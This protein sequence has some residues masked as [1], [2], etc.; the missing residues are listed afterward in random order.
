M[1]KVYGIPNCNTVKKATDWLKQQQLNYEFNDYKKHGVTKEKLQEWVA[2]FG[3]QALLN[4]AGTTWKQL[5]DE[6]KATI[7]DEQ[8]AL[9]LMLEKTSVIKR[10]IVEANGKYLIR[11]NEDE[12]S[13]TLLLK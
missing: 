3:W 12:Y 1:I 6:Q 13:N 7:V 11:F 10:P 8:T 2:H 9:N 5:T 4:K